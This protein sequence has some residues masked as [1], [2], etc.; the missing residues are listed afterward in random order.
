M[1]AVRQYID[2]FNKGDVE[3]MAATFAVPVSILD[4]MAPHVW[5]GLTAALSHGRSTFVVVPATMTFK[6]IGY[7]IRGLRYRGATQARRGVGAS[8]LGRGQKHFSVVSHARI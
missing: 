3:V 4:R 5:H 8:R 6:Q 7:T 1:A 2:G